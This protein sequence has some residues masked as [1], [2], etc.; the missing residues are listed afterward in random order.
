MKVKLL[1]LLFLVFSFFT[2]SQNNQNQKELNI[3]I[4]KEKL[5]EFYK[6]NMDTTSISVSIY[7][8]GYES[9]KKRTKCINDY[10]KGKKVET[11]IGMPTFSINFIGLTKPEK[12]ISIDKIDY[13]SV[14]QFVLGD[15]KT[16]NPTYI[17]RK[18]KD[19]TYLRWSTNE[20]TV[21]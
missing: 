20:M 11:S 4:K 17:I 6:I 12:L 18:Q 9:K 15:L 2:Y 16:S 19:G 7:I 14:K 8:N 10:K 1:T 21:E 5:I 3:F 13:I